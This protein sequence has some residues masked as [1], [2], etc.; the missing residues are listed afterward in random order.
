VDDAVSDRQKYEPILRGFV[1]KTCYRLIACNSIKI[2]YGERAKIKGQ[3]YIWI[4][5]PWSFMQHGELITEAYLCP[6]HEAIDYELR[7]REWCNLFHPLDESVLT[8]CEFLEDG[9]LNLFFHDSYQIH[10]PKDEGSPDDE[11]L[12]L[13]Y[14]QWYAS[15]SQEERADS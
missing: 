15:L 3:G 14:L 11:D 10:V 6:Y 13:W 5:P 1:G 8:S 9:S 4:D 2:R 12:E 7:F